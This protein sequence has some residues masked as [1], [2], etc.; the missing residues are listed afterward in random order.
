MQTILTSILAQIKNLSPVL[1]KKAHL[2]SF[3]SAQARTLAD[4]E[5]SALFYDLFAFNAYLGRIEGYPSFE[6]ILFWEYSVCLEWSESHMMFGT[7]FDLTLKNAKRFLG[8]IKKYFDYLAS[9][10]KLAD[11]MELDTAI[12]TI[13]GGKKLK[14]IKDIPYTGTETYTEIFKGGIGIRFDMADYWLLILQ[15]TLFDQD[16]TKL[17]EAAFGVSGARVK[18]VK[19]LQERMTQAGFENLNE[20]AYNDVTVSDADHAKTWFYRMD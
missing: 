1:F 10:G 20:I 11:S 15:A 12:K 8:S 19:S 3:F 5:L 4:A 14:L 9:A 16:W 13:C 17:L 2:T 7:A 6:K 18:K